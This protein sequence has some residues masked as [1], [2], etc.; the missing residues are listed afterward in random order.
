MER[1]LF[2][3]R[4]PLFANLPPAELKQVAAIA[5]EH[6]FIDGEVIAQQ[7]EPGDELYVIVS[8]QVRVLVT[9]TGEEDTELARRG[10][11]EY[12]GEMAVISQKPRMARLVALG[13][14]RTLCIEQKQFEGILRERPETS[15][16][17]MREL[18]DRLR[19]RGTS[20]H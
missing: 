15:L 13:D 20:A 2:L 8:G 4:V 10:T 9:V 17:V 19:E 1:I 11:G 5:D 16:A 18:C 12:V 3:K 14:V 6:L 7:N